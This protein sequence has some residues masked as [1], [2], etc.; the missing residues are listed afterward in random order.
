MSTSTLI[1]SANF[2][3]VMAAGQAEDFQIHVLNGP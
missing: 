1:L 2:L 3:H